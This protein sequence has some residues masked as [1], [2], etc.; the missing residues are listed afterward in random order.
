MHED[1]A[2]AGHSGNFADRVE[3][4]DLVVRMH[5]AHEL[6]ARRDRLPHVVGVHGPE[7]VHGKH[8]DLASERLEELARL[9]CRR[10]LD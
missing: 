9:R 5:D 1:A 3:C 7:L 2:L 8:R 4:P 10:V 6:R